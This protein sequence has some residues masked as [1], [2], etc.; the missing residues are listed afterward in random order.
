MWA[1]VSTSQLARL[2]KVPGVNLRKRQAPLNT[3]GLV[4]GG[5]LP[6]PPDP[7]TLSYV[8]ELVQPYVL[9]GFLMPYQREAWRDSYMREGYAL[10]WACGSGKTLGALLWVA[11]GPPGG[12]TVIVTRAPTRRQWQREAQNYTRLRPQ[13]L[14]GRTPYDI[15]S[16]VVILSWAVVQGWADALIQWAR[17]GALSIVWDELHKGKSWKRKERLVARD[18]SR[19]HT[20]LDNR[21]AAAAKLAEAATRRL[22]LTATPV[23]DRRSDLWAQLDLLEPGAWGSNWDWIHRYCNAR[24]G[25]FGGIDASGISQCGELKNRLG[26]ITHVVTYAEMTQHLPPKRRQLVYLNKDDQSRPAGFK[27][28]MKAA[29]KRGAQALFEMKLLEAASRKRA[30]IAET[31]KDAVENGQK[32]TVF[33]GRR[34]DCEALAKMIRT[35]LKG[36]CPKCKGG[37]CPACSGTGD[38][39]P[40]W[41]GHGG[42]STQVRDEI[43]S[44]YAATED[45]CAFIGTT[46][47]FG[48]AVDGLQNT[49]L[50]VFG[51]LP[52]TPGQV[53]QAEGR[54]SRH[55]SKRAVTIMYTV[56]EGTVDEHVA[57]LL[58]EKLEQV[59]ATLDDQESEGIAHTLGGVE[60]EETILANIIQLME[61]Q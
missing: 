42:D 50:V 12:K 54:F 6:V 43:V 53:T 49:D 47:A 14:S 23:R 38:R 41:S 46:D 15:E 59:V 9:D 3:L 4:G 19:Y 51:L 5:G 55:G 58:L 34:K 52:W 40:V 26:M 8:R 22:G 25:D 60:D 57:D 36:K 48:E 61:D 18:G 10:W 21:A 28:D 45:P 31:V 24:K 44:K 33:T 32:V 11:A 29:A 27:D 20:W 7:A 35:K 13:V 37:G 56:A 30:W 2:R 1:D 16:D 17:G 39:Y